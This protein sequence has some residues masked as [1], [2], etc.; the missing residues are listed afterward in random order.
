M[1]ANFN[2]YS[3]QVPDGALNVQAGA[4]TTVTVGN[5]GGGQPHVNM[6]P[7]LCVRFIIALE[8][9]YPSRP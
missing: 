2:T 8:G 4:T 3:N 7:W 6:Q 1:P 5:A 9:I